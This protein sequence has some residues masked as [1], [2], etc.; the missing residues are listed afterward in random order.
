VALCAPLTP[1][2]VLCAGQNYA[3]HVSEKP[4]FPFSWNGPAHF[5]KLPQ[6][7]V[8]HGAT[9]PYPHGVSEKLDY[10]VELAV[11]IGRPGRHIAAQDAWR[12]VAGYTVINDLALRDWQV[13]LLDEGASS[14]SLLGVSKNFDGST[15]I[16]PWLVTADDVRDPHALHV[17]CLVNGIVRQD[18]N[19]ANFVLGIP[20]V[21]AFFSR[22]LTLLP[23]TVIATGACGG[24]AWGMDPELGGTWPKPEGVDNPY[25]QSGDRVDCVVEA[26][27]TLTNFIGA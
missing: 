4:G 26:V 5:I 21:I 25:L 13:R 23:G 10:E 18:N 15:P 22:F 11:V 19:T 9:I 8:G 6:T 20:E 17:Q 2:T 7:I 24:T 12:H 1:P 27:G 14:V 16:G 3:A